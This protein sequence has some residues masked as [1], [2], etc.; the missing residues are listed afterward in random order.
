MFRA[1]YYLVDVTVRGTKVRPRLSLR[2]P[3]VDGTDEFDAL[4]FENLS[5][6]KQVG[7]SGVGVYGS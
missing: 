3:L 7:S 6:V 1:L 2:F 4:G 5:T